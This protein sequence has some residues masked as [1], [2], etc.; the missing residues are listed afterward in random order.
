MC[1]CVSV[2]VCVCWGVLAGIGN[3]PQSR[4]QGCLSGGKHLGC[5]PYQSSEQGTP[6]IPREFQS[7]Q[8]LKGKINHNI[9]NRNNFTSEKGAESSVLA[10]D[11]KLKC[12]D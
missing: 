7:I 5:G 4:V 10:A 11:L 12:T 6:K 1:V 8:N 2:C 3:K 9:S